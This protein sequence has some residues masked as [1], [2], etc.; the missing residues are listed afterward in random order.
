MMSEKQSLLD[1]IRAD[2][3][4]SLERMTRAAMDAHAAAT[5]PGSKAESKYD[6]RNLE[7]SYLAVGQARQLDE[8]AEAARIFE[9]LQLPDYGPNDAIDAGALVETELNGEPAFFLLVPAA[10][11]LVLSHLGCE[12]TLLTPESLLYRNLLGLR[13]GDSLDRPPLTVTNVS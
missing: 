12:L 7:A 8:L 6:T 2:L 13:S 1:R 10:G 4:A 5:D 9:S 11:G 3:R